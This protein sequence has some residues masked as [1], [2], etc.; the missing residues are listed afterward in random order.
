MN[1]V[2]KLSGVLLALALAG[3]TE[4]VRGA[5]TDCCPRCGCQ[6]Q[7]QM[8]CRPICTTRREE[9]TCWDAA[10]EEICLPRTSAA[11]GCCG[12]CADGCCGAGM[13]G[14]CGACACTADCKI[15]PR[16]RL[17][18]KTFIKEVPVIVW[19]VEYVC[20]GCAN[21][22]ATSRSQPKAELTYPGSG[23]TVDSNV[24]QAEATDARPGPMGIPQGLFL[25]SLGED[26]H[27]D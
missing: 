1:T 11:A 8:V 4:E 13:T 18:R 10:C 27:G 16:N 17:M 20:A 22:D 5:G 25:P 7:L 24:G 23:M 3:Q 26:R 12:Q 9:V 2:A 14:P 19:V 15:R 21:Q 6:G